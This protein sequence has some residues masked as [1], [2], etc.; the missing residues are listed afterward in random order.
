MVFDGRTDLR[1]W[2]EDKNPCVEIN[3]QKNFSINSKSFCIVTYI[4]DY[5][6]NFV[7]NVEVVLVL[8]VLQKILFVGVVVFSHPERNL[9]NYMRK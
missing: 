4:I 9:K 5:W 7:L 2:N 6:S 3:K 8:M 1:L